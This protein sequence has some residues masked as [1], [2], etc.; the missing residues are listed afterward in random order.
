MNFTAWCR[1][2]RFNFSGSSPYITVVG[3]SVSSDI[4]QLPG[5]IIITHT[6]FLVVISLF[7]TDHATP[8]QVTEVRNKPSSCTQ[9]HFDWLSVYICDHRWSF[10]DAA[11]M[12]PHLNA[13]CPLVYMIECIMYVLL[14]TQQSAVGTVVY[15][16]CC[17]MYFD[18]H[19][20][21][22]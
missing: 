8:L 10:L 22:I 11:Q 19:R 2:R 12:R 15:T 1:Q 5:P 6:I 16:T 18:V 4:S 3:T 17:V 21:N 13:F 9:T 20:I 14:C 7:M